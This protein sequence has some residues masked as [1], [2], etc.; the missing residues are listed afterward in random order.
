MGSARLHDEEQHTG[1]HT[2]SD[3]ARVNKVRAFR[4]T[5]GRSGEQ[6]KHINGVGFLVNKT[7]QKAIFG[8]HQV[9]SRL[10]SI[11]LRAKPFNITVVQVYAPTSDYDEEV[12][13]EFYNQLQLIIVKVNKKDILIIQ[14][15]WNAKVGVDAL[16]DWSEYCGP[17]SNSSTNERGFRLLEFASYNNMTLANTLG[18]HKE[19]RRWT[20]HAPNGLHHNQIDYILVQNRFRSSIN[21]PKT[22]TFPGADIGSDHDLVILNLKIR[23]KKIKP[24]KNMRLKFNIEK[25]KDPSI[26]ETFQVTIG[27]KFAPLL[28]LEEDTETM[29]TRFNAIMTETA[30]E[31]L[32]KHRH[33]NKPWVTD[34]I[35]ELCDLRRELKKTKNTERGAREYREL[36]KTVRN[37]MRRVKEEW[38]ESQCSEIEDCFNRNNTKRAYQIVNDLTKPRQQKS[39]NIQ[40]KHGN[41]L[42]EK[43]EISKRWTEYCSELYNHQ[44]NGDPTVLNC[45]QSTNLDDF[46]ILREEIELAIKSLKNGKTPGIDN[47]PGELIQN[48]GENMT[49]FLTRLCNRIWE[50]G[51]WPSTWTQSLIITLHKKGNIQQCSNYRTISLISH[52]S[53]VMLKVILNR[54][55][56]QAEE[57]IAAEQAGFRKGRSTTEQIFNLRVLGEKYSQH[58]QDIYHLFVDFKKAFDRVWHDALWATMHKYNMGQKLI[59]TIR[60]LYARA[61]SAVLM[62]GG[63]GDWFRTTVGVRQGCPLSPTLFNIFL[64]RIMTDALE[65][66]MGT[67]SI[68]GQTITN[69][70]FAD[71]IDVM[72]GSEEELM[73]VVHNLDTASTNYGMEISAEKSKIMTNNTEGIHTPIAVRGQLLET[74]QHF[75]YLG[76]I[77]NEEG[78]KMEILS[79][80]AQTTAA[81]AKLKTVWQDKNISLKIKQ[82]LLRA[83]VLSVFLYACETWTLTA[84]LQRR[85]Q[86]LEMRCFRRILGISYRDHITN[87]EVRRRIRQHLGQY[88][89]L[90]TTVKRRKLQSYGHT[91]RSDGLAKTI[92][93]GTVRGGRRR[94]RQR[95]R[96][97][98]NIKEWTE[99]SLAGAQALAHDRE[100]WR[101]HVYRSTV[102]RPHDPGGLREQ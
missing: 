7:I 94:G 14:G 15:D 47:I 70:R 48:G 65:D 46:P 45:P 88:E 41:C 66:H 77:I 44:I 24:A 61:G 60:Q 21:I 35:L 4:R 58:Q 30:N 56:P 78:S 67:V 95:K 53:K 32:G 59:E 89:D 100:G 98:D 25:L 23:W 85:I 71:D 31:V 40:D 39:N 12:I 76:S 17:S 69:L 57:I 68:G 92:L 75:K 28:A 11:R 6:D 73:R 99:R 101:D 49:I 96:W 18:T 72:A 19:S 20:W 5:S 29:T 62:Q 36:N 33:K 80:A 102:Q 8:C 63:V 43:D 84:E 87:E 9:S 91:I 86:A 52:A 38:I 64:E 27:G 42:T 16:N 3:V 34:D 26:R 79:R 83:I 93:Q 55:T 13:E 81:L 97:T 50:T 10:I 22:R 1:I 51:E 37:E 54:L 90:L 82:K 74:V 2:G